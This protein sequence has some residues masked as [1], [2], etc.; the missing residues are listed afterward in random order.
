MKLTLW[1]MA[2]SSFIWRLKTFFFFAMKLI[3]LESY[4]FVNFLFIQ[5]KYKTNVISS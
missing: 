4:K 3:T 1:V 5:H 2:Q